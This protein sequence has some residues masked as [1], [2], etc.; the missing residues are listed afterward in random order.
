MGRVIRRSYQSAE[1]KAEAF[2]VDGEL[3]LDS[4]WQDASFDECVLEAA[5][6]VV[7]LGAM[8]AGR[9]H[10]PA[11][12]RCLAPVTTRDGDAVCPGCGFVVDCAL[13][14]STFADFSRVSCIYAGYKPLFHLNERIA[15]LD[16]NDPHVPDDLFALVRDAH[17][18]GGYPTDGTLWY[19]HIREILRSVTVPP[20]LQEKYRGRRYTCSPLTDMACKFAERWITLR[21]RLTGVRP[22]ALPSH[23]ILGMQARL[24]GFMGAWRVLRHT[25]ECDGAGRC[26][27]RCGCRYKLPSL[28]L[29]MSLFLYDIGGEKLSNHY[30]PYLF[31]NTNAP[32]APALLQ[33]VAQCF[34]YNGWTARFDKEK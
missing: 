14:A 13:P 7:R 1:Q 34:K 11:C 30:D 4:L 12:D 20:H 31:Y 24:I 33:L 10:N 3:D 8:D 29:L 9:C 5:G 28:N 6:V 32:S 15:N 21:Y 17:A 19:G 25:A 16:C 22:P 26:H 2:R 23:A 27:W 18:A